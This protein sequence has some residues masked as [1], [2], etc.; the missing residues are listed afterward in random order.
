MPRKL[1]STEEFYP[2]YVINLNYDCGE[3]TAEFTD[4]ELADYHRVD[5]EWMEWQSKLYDK[6]RGADET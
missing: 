5:K 2:V 3:P 6:I 4:E 1:I